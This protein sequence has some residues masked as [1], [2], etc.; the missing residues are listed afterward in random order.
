MGNDFLCAEAPGKINLYL[1]VTGKRS[2]GYHTLESLFLPLPGVADN[3]AID[4]T[5]R[6]E[7]HRH[8]FI[9]CGFIHMGFGTA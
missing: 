1:K 3:I 8:Q 9:K 2:D 5:I 4:C 6:D 7:S